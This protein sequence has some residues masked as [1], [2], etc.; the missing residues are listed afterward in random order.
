MI[1]VNKELLSDELV[2][3]GDRRSRGGG[4][5]VAR[6]YP[7][8]GRLTRVVRMAGL[9]D[10]DAAV[11]R[12][13]IA[14]PGWRDVP[15][16]A[17]RDLMLRAATLL[18]ERMDRLA[19]IGAID[20]G[21]TVSG[22]RE[23]V[24]HA[25]EWL[26]YYAGWV[27]KISPSHSPTGTDALDYVRQEPYGVIGVISPSN[28]A[29]SAMVLAPL[30]A[31][32][33]CAVV[34]PSEFTS[35]VGV[36]YLQVFIDAGFPPGVVNSVPGNGTVGEALARHTGIDKVHFTGSC[37]VGAKVGAMAAL[38]LKP[39]CMELGGKS[40]NIVFD[41]ADLDVAADLCM[42]AL[43][44]QSGQS[45]VAGTRVIVHESVSERLLDLT[46]HRTS[47]RRIGDPLDPG[48][49]VGPMVS[50][51]SQQRILAAIERAT[52]EQFGRLVMGGGTLDT[53]PR[54]GY[55]VQPT[56][57]ANV[58]NSSPL[59]REETFGPVISFIPFRSD[60][61]A[62]EL[63]NDS[64]FGLAAYVQTS[65]LRRAHR[66]AIRLD[67][68]TVWVNG[69]P[70]IIPGS[71]F[72]GSKASGYGRVGGEHGLLEFSRSKNVWLSI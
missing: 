9:D 71:P 46:I 50:K 65:N 5:E 66:A 8:D 48:T 4:E 26:I 67:A 52:R 45:C 31:A 64:N 17:R 33:N 13:R 39:T 2:L 58:D 3:I 68:G 54:E 53:V 59:A 42:R 23:F 28:S 62:I 16:P 51:T 21:L 6:F 19:T 69:A 38:A 12:A 1:A 10:V 18:I 22:V 25:A 43:V 32:G 70:G 30:L 34:K 41:D 72:G 56:I 47:E 49:E 20:A 11:R 15:P 36:E 14:L 7:G 61:E 63:A 27:D 40:A 24:K 44:R 55:F 37:S 60:E 57:F 35:N 29:V